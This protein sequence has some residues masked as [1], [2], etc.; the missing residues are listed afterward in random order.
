MAN[1]ISTSFALLSATVL[2][3][4]SFVHRTPQWRA[5]T[6]R[7]AGLILAFG[8]LALAVDRDSWL[9]DT[10]HRITDWFVAQRNPTLDPIVFG[11]TNLFGPASMV[12][13]TGTVAVAIGWLRR[14]TL[15]GLIVV[16]TVGAAA[17]AGVL[18]KLLVA[19][20]RPPLMLQATFEHGYSFPSG[21]VTAATALCGIAA[22]IIGVT[23][24]RTFVTVLTAIAILAVFAVALSRLYL[25]VHWFSD[26]VA[27]ALLGS[28]AVSFG[29]AGLRALDPVRRRAL[30]PSKGL[31]DLKDNEIRR[32]S[33]I[34]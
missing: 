12:V 8:A 28:L 13:V 20:A 31:D 14:S 9:K 4:A 30:T 19:R 32:E 27:G 34:T 29:T 10:D 22:T 2:V 33:G 7:P 18:I 15:A 3:A 17:V 24:S 21:H 5:T 11:V 25:G 26:V 1:T 16:A 6:M 23:S